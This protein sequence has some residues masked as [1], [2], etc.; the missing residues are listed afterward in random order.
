MKLLINEQLWE[1][2]IALRDECNPELKITVSLGLL[3]H[4]LLQLLLGMTVVPPCWVGGLLSCR[5]FCSIEA[6]SFLEPPFPWSLHC[7]GAC[8][9]CGRCRPWNLIAWVWIQGPRPVCCYCWDYLCLPSFILPPSNFLSLPPFAV[10]W[11]KASHQGN[12][13]NVVLRLLAP[14]QNRKGHRRANM[15]PR[16]KYQHNQLAIA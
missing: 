13:G 5:C 10:I 3:D 16:V 12:M 4:L 7:H 6:H 8:W 9:A 11:M 14:L 1:A 15:K 2:G